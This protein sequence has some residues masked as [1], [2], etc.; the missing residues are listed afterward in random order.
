M[1]MIE[2]A[3]QIRN[4][5]NI[6]VASENQIWVPHVG[7]SPYSNYI[8]DITSSTTPQDLAKDFVNE[9]ANWLDNTHPGQ[10]GYTLSAVDLTQI[11]PLSTAVSN[12]GTALRSQMANY[13]AQIQT[14]RNNVQ[15][16]DSDNSNL[17]NSSDEYVD[18]SDLASELKA[19]PD[20]GVQ[21]GAQVVIDKVNAFIIANKA[22]S[23]TMKYTDLDKNRIHGVSIFFPPEIFKR[24]FYTGLNLDFASGTTWSTSSNL[25]S[26]NSVVWGSFLVDFVES[27]TPSAPDAPNPPELISPLEPLD[28]AIYLPLVKR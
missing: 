9:Y 19:I 18:L 7:S 26:T 27:I 6:Y 4:Y 22:N 12:L 20:T 11:D 15:K 28:S 5:A 8:M 24:S 3:Y 1:G 25:A 23:G 16:F 14:A 2:D 10:L 13:G 17:I 21:N